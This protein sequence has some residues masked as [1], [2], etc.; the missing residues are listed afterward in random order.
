[1]RKARKL[2]SS[3]LV[4]IFCFTFFGTPVSA[5]TKSQTLRVFTSEGY[6]YIGATITMKTSK[7]SDKKGTIKFNNNATFMGFDGCMCTIPSGAVYS[8]KAD[9]FKDG[10]KIE[11]TLDK[12]TV[13]NEVYKDL[14]Y[15]YCVNLTGKIH[16]SGNSFNKVEKIDCFKVPSLAI[17][18]W[19]GVTQKVGF[20][21][22][23]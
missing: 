18:R 12:D 21:L 22:K 14:K 11:L 5:A 10:A 13:S 1:M 3:L 15:Y 2:V 17:A 23:K 16:T 7:S 8:Y 4:I 19:N 20:Y 6:S 9:S